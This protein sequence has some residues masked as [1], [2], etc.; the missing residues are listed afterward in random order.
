MLGRSR[1]SD[2]LN[3]LD[4]RRN[5]FYERLKENINYLPQRG[6]G[7]VAAHVLL[8]TAHVVPALLLDIAAL[9]MR[10]GPTIGTLLRKT[11]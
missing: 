1:F 2:C 7:V 5:F 6:H 3:A 10:R 4:S 11:T 8:A 9:L